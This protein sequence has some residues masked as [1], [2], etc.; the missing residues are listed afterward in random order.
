[1]KNCNLIFLLFLV[2]F[3]FVH[4]QTYKIVG[5]GTSMCYDNYT[6]IECPQ[7]TGSPFYGQ[8]FRDDNGPSYIDNGNGTIA[9]FYTG[10]TW[11]SNPDANGN[12]DGIMTKSDKL[13]WQQV[14]A[15]ILQIN[16][17]KYGGYDDWR[18]P[19]I[20]ELYSLTNWGGTDPSGL[21]SNSTTGLTPFIDNKYF[22]F[23]WGQVSAG[24]RLIDVQYVSCT[25]YNEPGAM[26]S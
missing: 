14:Q 16:A 7:S 21:Q 6:I 13:T 1:M 5:T 10:L 22:P 17:A 9:D 19:T 12:N 25:I 11:Q 24:E 15:K 23:V 18:I 8:F 4:A 3:S 20:K 2:C 26:G